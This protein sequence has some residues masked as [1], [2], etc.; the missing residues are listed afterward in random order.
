MN[1]V[2]TPIETTET[3]SGHTWIECVVLVFVLEYLC[4]GR[5][6]NELT[7]KYTERERKRESEMEGLREV[8]H[9]QSLNFRVKK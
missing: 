7:D 8:F 5:N 6:E 4:S 3:W 2:K 9:F 1:S